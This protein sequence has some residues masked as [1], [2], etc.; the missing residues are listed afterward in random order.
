[1]EKEANLH[2]AQ[3]VLTV[4]AQRALGLLPTEV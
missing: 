2:A 4:A 3:S 1:M